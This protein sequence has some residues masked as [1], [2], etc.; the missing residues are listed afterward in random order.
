[1]G[2]KILGVFISIFLIWGGLSGAFV[3]RGTNSSNALVVAGFIFLV[4]DILSIALHRKQMEEAEE[5]IAII[6]KIIPPEHIK[7][8]TELIEQGMEREAIFKTLKSEGLVGNEIS[9][10]YYEAYHIYL[11]KQEAPLK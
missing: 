1:M 11:K 7:R 5:E 3:L 9:D 4:L 6:P 2:K 10:A 8:A